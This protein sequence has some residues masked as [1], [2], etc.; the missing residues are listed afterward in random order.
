MKLPQILRLSTGVGNKD[1]ALTRSSLPETQKT[2]PAPNPIIWR[3][4]GQL[5]SARH[6]QYSVVV[7]QYSTNVLAR[8]S[9]DSPLVMGL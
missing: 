4:P 6:G 7:P 8:Q 2:G 1:F 5:W 9:G 3:Q